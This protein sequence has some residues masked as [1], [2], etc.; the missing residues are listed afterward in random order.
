MA[1]NNH[2]VVED[3]HHMLLISH[4][5][6]ASDVYTQ[7][8]PPQGA[9]KPARRRR[10][11]RKGGEAG[12][13]VGL[14][15]RKLTAEQVNLLELNFGNEHKL[16]SEKKDRLASELGLDPRQVAVWFQNRRARWK[17]KK[18]E[19]EY[20]TLKKEHENTVAEKC[21]LESE[22]SKLKDQLSEAEMEIQ[23]LLERVDHGGPSNSPSSSFS[24][25]AID[26][27]FLGEFGVEEYDDVFYMPQNNYIP[28]MEWMN[29]YM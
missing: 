17:N 10:K 12:G 3:D 24:M 15:K 6:S 21:R 19:E 2:Q 16:E 5:Y 20:S 27:P 13:V 9:S 11:K 22:M 7:I 1:T 25:E 4:L 8:V 23:R 14:K 26:P 18:L 28:G 29:L